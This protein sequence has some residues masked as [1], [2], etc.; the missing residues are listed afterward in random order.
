MPLSHTP[1]KMQLINEFM[2]VHMII[3][4]FKEN[5]KDKMCTLN[6]DKIVSSVCST[7]LNDEKNHA[8]STM[9]SKIYEYNDLSY[10][11]INL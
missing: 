2:F 9:S 10:S 7:C 4:V 1:L 3:C 8:C 5:G 11:F 6:P